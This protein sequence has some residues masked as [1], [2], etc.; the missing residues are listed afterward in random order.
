MPKKANWMDRKFQT[1][2]EQLITKTWA[3]QIKQQ[4][5]ERI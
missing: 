1:S 2:I 5:E 4:F 3:K